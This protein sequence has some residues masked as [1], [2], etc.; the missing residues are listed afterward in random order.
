VT[1][2]ETTSPPNSETVD[3]AG[4]ATADASGAVTTDRPAGESTSLRERA[5]EVE[6]TRRQ[7][8][9]LGGG[10]AALG[11]GKAVD[12][13]L[14]GY[15]VLVGENLVSQDLA[16]VAAER[17]DASLGD[18]PL[19][20]GHRAA[21]RGERLGV[22]DGDDE[23]VAAVSLPSDSNDAAAVDDELGFAGGPV[24]ELVR[25]LS[26]I[27]RG[28]YEFAFSKRDGF[29]DRIDAAESRAFTTG[30]LRG[31]YYADEDPETIQAFADADPTRPRAV[32]DGLVGGFR[33]YSSYDVPRYLAGSVEDN[34]LLGAVDLRQHFR[35]E[36]DFDAVREDDGTGMFCWEFVNRSLEALHAV[37]AQRQRRPAVG[38]KVVDDRHK[39]VYTGVASV[40]R[41]DGDLVIPA[42]FVDYTH[43]TLYDDF[44]LT[45]VLGEGVEA[46][47]E[48]HRATDIY[49]P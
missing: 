14:I 20:D 30:A 44:A 43:S 47:N 18:S 48:R 24:E 33:E 45:G 8:L 6:I 17:L 1:D 27:R 21:V 4:D 31:P 39:H 28:E 22:V 36:A 15:G 25:D 35:T 40:V 32:L 9:G 38:L 42:T 37:P 26:A 10:A 7:A 19:P 16:A 46:Y 23:L 11:G 5:G 34:V 41:E 29:F 12:N 13:V 2:R 3:P 49:W